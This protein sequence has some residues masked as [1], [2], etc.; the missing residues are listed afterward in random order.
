VVVE[1]NASGHATRL[2]ITEHAERSAWA[3]LW[4]ALELWMRSKRLGNCSRQLIK[5]VATVRSMDVALPVKECHSQE[6][7]PV[8]LQVV[9]RSIDWPSC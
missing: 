5:E 2:K 6:T 1:R 8:R 7:R 3:E 9:A 4:R